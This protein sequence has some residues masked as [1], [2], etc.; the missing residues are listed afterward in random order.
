ME[1]LLS[2]KELSKNYL[3]KKQVICAVKDVSFDVNDEDFISIIG[4]SGC[5]KS[6]ILSII[7]N[8]EE[9]SKGKIIFKNNNIKIG[10][11]F[12]E[13]ALF[14]WLTVFGN[15]ILGLKIKKEDTKE[16]ITYVK[17]LLEK[18]GLSSFINSYPNE[19]SGGMRQRVALI[20]TLSLRPDILLLDEA[21]SKL[22]YQT[23]IK[24]SNDVKRIIKD[25]GKTAIMVT[26]DI[27]EAIKMANKVIV[28]SKRPSVVKNIYE[29]KNIKDY[30]KYY[31]MLWKDLDYD[32]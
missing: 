8:L 21:F 22:D 18:Y 15:C 32:E 25:E 11:M 13:D 31:D 3:T 30:D 29:I 7:G 16:N 10:Y 1:K 19:L 27:G 2:I 9:K 12:Q 20:R 6:T 28:L 24:V 14:P 5:G 17:S 4:P 26:H 23:R